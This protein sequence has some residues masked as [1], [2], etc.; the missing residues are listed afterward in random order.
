MQQEILKALQWRYATKIFDPT[1][2]ISA[3]DLHT[4]LESGRLAPSS[5]GTEP[6]KFLVVENSELRAKL[7]AGAYGQPKVTDA[8]ALIVFTCRT[9]IREHIAQEL[10]DRTAAQQHVEAE[11]L[12]GLRAMVEGGIAAKQDADLHAWMRS[13]VYISLGIMTETASLLGID[14]C[15]M[16]GFNP[17]AVDEILGLKAQNLASVCML[18][19]GTRGED[20]AAARP[21]VRRPFEEV[22]EFLK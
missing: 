21:K 16:E 11:S 14:N 10:I 6:W 19:L 7:R 3:E 17:V 9:D 4:I 12:E 2:K 8:A 13:Q 20:P 18:A 22:V 1:K 15:A 5:I